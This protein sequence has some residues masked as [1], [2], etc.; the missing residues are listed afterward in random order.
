MTA[1]KPWRN[2]SEEADMIASRPFAFIGAEPGTGKTG[3]A[4]LG[5]LSKDAVL[6]VCPIAV[7]PAWV[8]QFAL[9]DPDRTV[10][11]AVE[12]KSS[13]RAESILEAVNGSRVAVVVN[14]D[15]M[16]RGKLGEAIRETK[17]DAIVLDESHKIK[18]PSGRASKFA[19]KLAKEQPSATRVCL[20]GTPTPHSPLDWWSQFRFL[21]ESVLGK[22][23]TA[24]RAR[25]AD[26]HPRFPGMITRFKQDALE[27]LSKRID[28][29]VYRIRMDDVL[30]LP[31]MIH[32]ELPV[33]LDLPS[34]R[35]YR[36]LEAELTATLET[37]ERV[38]AANRLSV[39]TRLQ[40]ATSGYTVDE[41]GNEVQTSKKNAKSDVFREWLENLSSDEPLVV[42]CRFIR[43]IDECCKVL[44]ET[45]RTVSEL[46]GRKKQLASWQNGDT[47]SLV[48]QQ[49]AGGVGVDCTRA[50]FACYYSLSHSLGDYEQSLARLRRPGQTRVTRIYHLVSQKTI[51]TTI[52]KSL[53]GKRDVVEEV[54]NR[55][56][57][58]TSA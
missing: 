47:L 7:G 23:Y 3:A 19:A 40:Q 37:G 11:L 45:G 5:V 48:V 9:W 52:Y 57:R 18:S 16:W 25:I 49:Q 1:M 53:Q 29:H 4:I 41:L 56:T 54:L 10:V 35:F 20:S 42:F 44:R 14:Y 33:I 27:A 15:A 36:E 21:D 2:Q 30:D 38:T 32:T 6:V 13:D 28:E 26:T 39:I 17:W 43:D 55:L 58:R 46:S 50:A 22:S 8:K 31:E 51:D 24:Y 12:G 34:L